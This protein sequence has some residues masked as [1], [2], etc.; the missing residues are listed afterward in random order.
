ML[1]FAM[2]RSPDQAALVGAAPR[3]SK[4]QAVTVLNS[5]QQSN[6]RRQGATIGPP[7]HKHMPHGQICVTCATCISR[8][9]PRQLCS[10]AAC[11]ASAPNE[12]PHRVHACNLSHMAPPHCP[13]LIS[14]PSHMPRPLPQLAPTPKLVLRHTSA[15]PPNQTTAASL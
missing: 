11:V 6:V 15:P 2:K 4:T 9:Q 1:R 12:N 10:C 5:E 3:R 7:P 14:A 13:S 8:L